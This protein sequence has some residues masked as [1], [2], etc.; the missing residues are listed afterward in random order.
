MFNFYNFTPFLFL[1]L[2]VSVA[3]FLSYGFL[4]SLANFAIDLTV[5]VAVVVVAA[6]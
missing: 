1:P 4:N 2:F 5:V 3:T 6:T